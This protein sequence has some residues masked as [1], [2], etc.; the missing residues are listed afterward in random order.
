MPSLQMVKTSNLLMANQGRNHKQHLLCTRSICILAGIMVFS[1][2]L[3]AFACGWWGDGEG[4]EVDSIVIGADGKPVIEQKLNFQMQKT[5]MEQAFSALVPVGL[6]VP[7]PRSGYGIA[8][9]NNEMA[10]PYLSIISDKSIHTIQQLRQ[11]GFAAVI[12]FSHSQHAATLHREETGPLGMIYFNIPIKGDAAAEQDVLKF[13]KIISTKENQPIVAFS[14]SAKLLGN[15]WAKHR[16]FEGS[17]HEDAI[18]QGKRLGLSEA[19]AQN[20]KK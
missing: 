15:I 10:M 4:D 3:P 11:Y 18:R 16:L 6:E 8:V 14:S 13:R 20:L 9:I 19:D 12:D 2:S 5:D 17:S 7:A 1:L